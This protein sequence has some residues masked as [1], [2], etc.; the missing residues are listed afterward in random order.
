MQKKPNPP[1]AQKATHEV[2]K[3]KPA[4]P[5]TA[6]K[7][8]TVPPK[9]MVTAL[10]RKEIKEQRRSSAPPPRATTTPVSVP[11]AANN[12]ALQGEIDRFNNLQ[13][14]IMLTQINDDLEDIEGAINALPANLENIRT[15]GY[16]F[17]NYLE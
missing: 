3:P 7:A 2:S 16:V 6:K 5:P 10:E 12:E 9:P 8:T 15:R 4:S 1:G 17:K 11:A 14:K 13:G